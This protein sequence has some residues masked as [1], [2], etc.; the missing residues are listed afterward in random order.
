MRLRQKGITFFG[1]LGFLLI[2]GF[3]AF[4]AMR[5]FPAYTE[6]QNV[7]M[8][9]KGLAEEPGIASKDG[10][11]IKKQLLKRLEISYV[12]NVKADNI[13]LKRAKG[14]YDVTVKYEVRKP[15]AYNLEYV[16]MFEKTVALRRDNTEGDST[17]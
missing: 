14:G 16:A 9:M 12:D 2:G 6:Y 11:Q 4:L 1:F 13:T 3:F 5:L 8:S 17:E 10:H 7:S 15:L